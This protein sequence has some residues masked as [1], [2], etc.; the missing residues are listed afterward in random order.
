MSSVNGDM[1][2]PLF[3]GSVIFEFLQD[4]NPSELGNQTRSF[5]PLQQIQVCAN[6]ISPVQYIGYKNK[7]TFSIAKLSYRKVAA[8]HSLYLFVFRTFSGPEDAQ[9]FQFRLIHVTL[10]LLNIAIGNGPF[11]DDL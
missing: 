5:E 3:L 6:K 2:I 9:K 1:M 10:W 8:N 11:K 7:G 4:S